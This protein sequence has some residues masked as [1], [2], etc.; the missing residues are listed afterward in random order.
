MLKKN[1]IKEEKDLKGKIEKTEKYVEKSINEFEIKE[2][3]LKEDEIE[4]PYYF[5]TK[6]DEIKKEIFKFDEIVSK[7]EFDEYLRERYR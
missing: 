1:E 5:I 7:E 6:N 2:A 3:L 4:I